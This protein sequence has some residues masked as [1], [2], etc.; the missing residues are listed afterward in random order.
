ML[1]QPVARIAAVSFKGTF[2]P[3]SSEDEDS[4]DGGDV[5]DG[6]VD[7]A[8]WPG[9]PFRIR[10]ERARSAGGGDEGMSIG[11][12]TE[13]TLFLYWLLSMAPWWRRAVDEF[14]ESARPREDEGYRHT[15]IIIGFP[16]GFLLGCT[17]LVILAGRPTSSAMDVVASGASLSV[18]IMVACG[19]VCLLWHKREVWDPFWT[20][21]VVWFACAAALLVLPAVVLMRCAESMGLLGTL[22]F[23]LV[24]WLIGWFLLWYR[25]PSLGWVTERQ[26]LAAVPSEGGIGLKL[27]LLVVAIECYNYAG[28]AFVPAVPW[29]AVTEPLGL[30]SVSSIMLAGF[31]EQPVSESIGDSEASATLGL[32]YWTFVAALVVVPVAFV[33][34]FLTWADKAQNLVV[35][36]VC[37]D[38]LSFPLM[39]R[40][41]SV[42]TCTSDSIWVFKVSSGGRM[43]SNAAALADWSSSADEQQC[44]GGGAINYSC[45][46]ADYCTPERRLSS[47]ARSFC[48]LDTELQPD[49]VGERFCMNN[50]PTTVCWEQT[51]LQYVL[52]AGCLL[53]AYYFATLALQSLVQA[54]QSVVVVDGSWTFLATQSRFFLAV[55]ASAYGNCYPTAMVSCIAAVMLVQLLLV[56]VTYSSVLTINSVRVGGLLCGLFNSVAAAFVLVRVG[57]P[58]GES[59]CSTAADLLV[60]VVEA[61]GATAEQQQHHL[62]ED[63]S[64]MI[65]VISLNA[66][67][68]MLGFL[69]LCWKHSKW[70]DSAEAHSWS[71]INGEVAFETDYPILANRLKSL[72][73][74]VSAEVQRRSHAQCESGQEQQRDK[75]FGQTKAIM[76]LA[77]DR[78][79][80]YERQ[81]QDLTDSLDDLEAAV[82]GEGGG[83]A[84]VNGNGWLLDVYLREE[85][86]QQLEDTTL[87]MVLSNELL[88]FPLGLNLRDLDLTAP[89]GMMVLR[90][91]G[92]YGRLGALARKSVPPGRIAS[93]QVSSLG[94][95]ETA[96]KF[97]TQFRTL[98][99]MGL[100]DLDLSGNRLDDGMM[101]RMIDS[102]KH[103]DID[104]VFL[105]LSDCNMGQR[106]LASLKQIF[107]RDEQERLKWKLALSLRTVNL[108]GNRMTTT[109]SW[110]DLRVLFDRNVRLSS[111]CGIA[112]G[113]GYVDLSRSD[114]ASGDLPML[115]YEMSRLRYGMV[116][117][118]LN[119]SGNIMLTT[120]PF[121]EEFGQ[122]IRRYGL[123]KLNLSDCNIDTAKM[124]AFVHSL[125]PGFSTKVRQL[126]DDVQAAQDY[127]HQCG[128]DVKDA[129]AAYASALE[130]VNTLPG[131]QVE[132]LQARLA[133]A[134]A[135]LDDVKAKIESKRRAEAQ[136]EIILAPEEVA[137][138]HNQLREATARQT[139]LQDELVAERELLESEQGQFFRT[140]MSLAG[141]SF[142]K[143]RNRRPGSMREG[144]S[145]YNGLR[146][147]ERKFEEFRTQRD[148]RSA[149]GTE[150]VEEAQAALTSWED[151]MMRDV[152][153]HVSM[154]VQSTGAFRPVSQ[155]EKWSWTEAALNDLDRALRTEAPEIYHDATLPG[156]TKN[157]IAAVMKADEVSIDSAWPPKEWYTAAAMIFGEWKRPGSY[158][159]LY[160][161]A[162]AVKQ[163]QSHTASYLTAH[164]TFWEMAILL[165]KGNPKSELEL[166]EHGARN[167]FHRATQRLLAAELEIETQ[168]VERWTLRW[169]CLDGNHI[170][171]EGARAMIQLFENQQTLRTLLGIREGATQ[172]DLCTTG[173][174]DRG[175][176][177]LIV[178]E[179]KAQRAA[180]DIKT[181]HVRTQN[182]MSTTLKL[183]PSLQL[184]LDQIRVESG[185]RI[186]IMT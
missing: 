150:T 147:A 86:D 29:Q 145:K 87:A 124:L 4:D 38:L 101:S 75:D 185:K 172:L 184:G 23:L 53:V 25:A 140:L 153:T 76:R 5:A 79:M 62:Q 103:A 52:L 43:I 15:V 67:A 129:E 176:V 173:L 114:G 92:R 51:H 31:F 65:V 88:S 121:L 7:G 91:L 99:L 89:S 115:Q 36:L 132:V 169:I 95:V 180:H 118:E 148:Q 108:L 42:L 45:A 18:A 175:H 93:I 82:Q 168:R 20:P 157:D 131:S 35:I 14:V 113:I 166:K 49:A 39:K 183:L 167:A 111:L 138:L 61:A 134:A 77:L 54:H 70:S 72:Q 104:L 28:C 48:Q 130:Y 105:D 163:A 30:P 152:K 73:K 109:S 33:L 55:M 165:L 63:W 154:R 97:S 136:G 127:Q 12:G 123:K 100:T 161:I 2:V 40:L 69:W 13:T 179:L 9:T 182:D 160:R 107:A 46:V 26:H 128:E 143:L 84:A 19:G 80:Y 57:H 164:C 139:E 119:L 16:L 21:F 112:P 159:P 141:E 149:E 144:S 102:I 66:L 6:E 41:T 71:S 177:M 181:I 110:S 59:T 96:Q 116:L 98:A 32:M 24:L 120:V 137:E 8:A 106:S 68:I 81:T 162:D 155:E 83:A 125:S 174:I 178:A 171:R 78:G 27:R 64:P 17:A 56:G 3:S 58:A 1:R 34:L 90:F 186:I 135:Q 122:L 170:G 37:F 94:T 22:L 158:E 11:T 156:V 133:V 10:E 74:L 117:T 60:A 142:Y 47:V 151:E 44:C 146:T 50:D 85:N 126:E